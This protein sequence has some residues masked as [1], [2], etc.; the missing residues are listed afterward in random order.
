MPHR[1]A[2]AEHVKLEIND[3]LEEQSS[4]WVIYGWKS[5]DSLAGEANRFRRGL[6]PI[7]VSP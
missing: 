6:S 5:R 3:G 2:S 4:E 7:R 1:H